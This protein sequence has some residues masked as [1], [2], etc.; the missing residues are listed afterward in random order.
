MSN[1]EPLDATA[2]TAS[3]RREQQSQ[4]AIGAVPRNLSCP[5]VDGPAEGASAAACQ[6]HHAGI[7]VPW[8]S[9]GC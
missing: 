1:V 8:M 2:T 3:G 9:G 7:S 5:P 6:E 4:R